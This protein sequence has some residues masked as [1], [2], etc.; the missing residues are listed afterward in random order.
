MPVFRHN[1][2]VKNHLYRA[3]GLHGVFEFA[4]ITRADMQLDGA[5]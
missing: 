4:Q 3:P 5:E 2:T 1:R